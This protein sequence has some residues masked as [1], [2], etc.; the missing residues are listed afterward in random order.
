[1]RTISLVFSIEISPFPASFLNE[2]GCSIVYVLFFRILDEVSV[3]VIRKEI[4][5]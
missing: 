1:M 2:L 5:S 3:H 4:E